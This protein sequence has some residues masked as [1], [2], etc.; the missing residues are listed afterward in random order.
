MAGE[1][2]SAL[3]EHVANMS[4]A[5]IGGIMGSKAA[6]ANAKIAAENARLSTDQAAREEG[7]IRR[8]RDQLV[9]AQIAAT[10]AS[11]VTLDGSPSSVIIDSAVAEELKALN[12]RYAG[13]VRATGYRNQASAYKLEAKQALYGGLAAGF[14]GAAA[15]GFGAQTV[16]GQVNTSGGYRVPN[17]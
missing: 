12:A 11:G 14:G 15:K 13:A 8:E 1:P 2:I 6:K 10:G 16:A 4:T 7:A 3:V 17:Y 9:G 5:I